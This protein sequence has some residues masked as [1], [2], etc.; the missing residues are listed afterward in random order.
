LKRF[1]TLLIFLFPVGLSYGQDINCRVII[2]SEG[3]ELSDKTI[4]KDMQEAI[5]DFV[6]NTKWSADIYNP[7]ERI[8]LNLFLT[9]TDMPS[10]TSFRAKVQI[11]TARPVFGASYESLLFN[12]LDEE[13]SFSYAQSAPLLYSETRYDS[14]LTSLLA[15]FV[16]IAIGMDNDSFSP[17]SGK[18]YYQKAQD[19]LVNAQQAGGPG[20]QSYGS[21]KSR[22][23]IQEN[24][25]SQ[26]FDKFRQSIYEYHRNGL[27]IMMDNPED[28]RKNIAN[29]L[30]LIQDVMKQ[31]PLSSLINF[32]LDGKRSE[33]INAFQEGEPAVKKQAYDILIEMDPTKTDEYEKIIKG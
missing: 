11:T 18:P 7:E 8:K 9:I 20:W 24:L 15:F 19:A 1:L 14:E 33:I 5:R 2:N 6:N 16:Y 31:V 26:I 32:Y 21:S 22:Y 10:L 27:D 23:W 17:V 13:W 4:F 25:N 29:S 12:Y 28:G 3:V 30:K